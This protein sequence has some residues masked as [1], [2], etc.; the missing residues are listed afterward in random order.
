MFIHSKVYLNFPVDMKRKRTRG[1]FAWETFTRFIVPGEKYFLKCKPTR[2]SIWKAQVDLYDFHVLWFIDG[3]IS[4]LFIFKRIRLSVY[5]QNSKWA[6][7]LHLKQVKEL[8]RLLIR[9]KFQ[10][11][12]TFFLPFFQIWADN[13]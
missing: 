9:G 13:Y 8:Y 2:V 7:Y 3:S 1:K 4:L 10:F 12:F 11:F 6:P 5:P